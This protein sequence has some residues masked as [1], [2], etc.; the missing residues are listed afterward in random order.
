[1]LLPLSLT[2]KTPK[3]SFYWHHFPFKFK[4]CP[5]Q[6]L[7]AKKIKDTKTIGEFPHEISC[8]FILAIDQSNVPD[9]FLSSEYCHLL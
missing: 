1:M 9:W 5:H 4:S 7:S 3:F 8:K 6:I 2:E